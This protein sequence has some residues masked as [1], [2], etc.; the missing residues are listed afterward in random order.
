MAAPKKIIDKPDG[1]ELK[2]YNIYK[3]LVSNL[4]LLTD[5]QIAS[6]HFESWHE[7]YNRAASVA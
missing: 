6:I 1:Q 4:H 3:E 2:T 5:E 7:A